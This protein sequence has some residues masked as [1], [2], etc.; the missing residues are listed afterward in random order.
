[1]PHFPGVADETETPQLNYMEWRV[2]PMGKPLERVRWVTSTMKTS[3]GTLGRA[4]LCGMGT[5]GARW[6][7]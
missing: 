7:V 4:G 2:T 6:R 3:L 5:A 1:M